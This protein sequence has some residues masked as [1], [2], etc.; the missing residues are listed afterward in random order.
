MKQ[1]EINMKSFVS[2]FFLL[3]WIVGIVIAKGFWSTLFS[4]FFFPW[5]WYLAVEHVLKLN[6]WL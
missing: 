2:I 3:L 1:I 5:A 4:I 6:G